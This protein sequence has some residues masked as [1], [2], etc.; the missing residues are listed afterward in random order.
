M[1]FVGT[2]LIPTKVGRKELYRSKSGVFYRIS[3]GK[4]YIAIE[5]AENELEASND[6]FDDVD[7]FDINEN[8]TEKEILELVRPVVAKYCE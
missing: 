3:Q 2:N 6:V 8:M 7:L 4:R 5:F 1:F